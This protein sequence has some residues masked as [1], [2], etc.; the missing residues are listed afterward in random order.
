MAGRFS[1]AK[2]I[3]P[4]ALRNGMEHNASLQQAFSILHMPVTLSGRI[5][6]SELFFT[7]TRHRYRRSLSDCQP[8]L[9]AKLSLHCLQAM[10][11]DEMLRIGCIILEKKLIFGVHGQSNGLQTISAAS[12]F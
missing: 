1:E 7:W 12:V 2:A 5:Y 3:E 10:H 6:A 11:K 9:V 8:F 4:H